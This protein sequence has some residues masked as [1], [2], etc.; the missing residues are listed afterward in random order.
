[1]ETTSTT[2]RKTPILVNRNFAWL[3]TGQAISM[4]GDMVFDTALVLWIATAIA[5]DQP[6]APLA[7]S[8]VLIV[9][10]LP[11]LIIRP[12]A[13]VFVDRW[14]KRQ[15]ML[16]MDAIRAA[17]IALLVLATGSIA[18]PFIPGG[19]LPV[20]WQ[21]GTIYGIV[22]LASACAQFFNPSRLALTGDVVADPQRGRAFGLDY[23][24]ENVAVVVGPPL[25]GRVSSILQPTITVASL[26]SAAIAGALASTV[27]H[28]V[29]AS[30]FGI[31]IG[32][33]DTIFTGAGILGLL[34]G[35]YAMLNLHNLPPAWDHTDAAPASPA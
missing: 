13:G 1:M 15:T 12:F 17:L 10:S 27:L 31:N 7:V 18:L 30:I 35:L 21:L 16:R 25:A 19:K 34:G 28:D 33:I 26:L 5:Q 22:F 11:M 20:A 29:H 3:W 9:T 4:L 6:W 23:V 24:T 8:G 14:D 32:P 2:A